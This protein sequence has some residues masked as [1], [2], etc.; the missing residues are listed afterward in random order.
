MNLDQRLHTLEIQKQRIEQ[1]IHQIKILIEKSSSFTKV[2]KIQLF[3][4][5]F[6]SPQEG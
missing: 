2:Q 3:K 6:I 5:L 1:E 4:S